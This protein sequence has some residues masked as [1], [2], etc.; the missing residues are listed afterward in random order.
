MHEKFRKQSVVE[1]ER[2]FP[3]KIM[4]T[5]R[6]ILS[7]KTALPPSTS[8]NFETGDFSHAKCSLEIFFGRVAQ[9]NST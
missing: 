5:V 9:K 1:T 7:D 3:P 8:Q 4:G 6:Q 2:G